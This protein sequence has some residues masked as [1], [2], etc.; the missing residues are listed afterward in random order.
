MYI[1]TDISPEAV[2]RLAKDHDTVG[3][4]PVRYVMNHPHHWKTAKV[5]R[6]LSARVEELGAANKRL[7]EQM[8]ARLHECVKTLEWVETPYW[9]TDDD[10]GPMEGV[11]HKLLSWQCGGYQIIRQKSRDGLF[12]LRGA[13]E[14]FAGLVF[15]T[16]KAA[17]A[18]A[19]AHY[20]AQIIEGLDL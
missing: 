4:D 20:A 14:D 19:Q 13:S 5:L 3:N 6:K 18:A 11:R 7:N 17:K 16:L 1:E 9:T 12:I 15:P 10:G 2:E 8:D